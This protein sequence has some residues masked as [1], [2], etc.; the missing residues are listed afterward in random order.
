MTDAKLVEIVT[1][2]CYTEEEPNNPSRRDLAERFGVTPEALKREWDGERWH[3]IRN[4]AL[5]E[6]TRV[7]IEQIETARITSRATEAPPSETKS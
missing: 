7:R 3:T 6:I 4:M 5:Q 1:D 2:C